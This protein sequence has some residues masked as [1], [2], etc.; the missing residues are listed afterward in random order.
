[1]KNLF[2]ATILALFLLVFALQLQSTW[3]QSLII[4]T[5]ILIPGV[6][7]LG[8]GLRIKQS[9]RIID[10]LEDG[11]VD[12]ELSEEG[13]TTTSAIGQSKLQWGIFTD[14]VDTPE[15]MLLM[16]TNQQ[17]ITLPKAQVSPSFFEAIN[18]YM[19]KEE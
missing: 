1:M 16:Y 7:I 10:L 4:T 18:S 3:L 12:I 15:S 6:L 9:L 14:M 13:L 19:K 17:F 11:K 2:W 5:V 8:Y